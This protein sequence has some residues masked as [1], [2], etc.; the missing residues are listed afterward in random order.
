M[1]KFISC[2]IAAMFSAGVMAQPSTM[3][4]AGASTTTVMTTTIDN[5]C[6]TIAF[7]MNGMTS[8]DITLPQLNGMATIPSFTISNAAFAMGANHVVTFPEQTF[9]SSVMDNGVEKTIT[10]TS[11]SG[12]YNMADNSFDITAVLKYGAMPLPLTYHIKGYYIKSVTNSI[13]VVVG[14]SFTYK[15]ESVTYNVRKYIEDGIEKVDVEVPNYTL[16]ATVIG[17]LNVGY[18]TIKGL[19]YD[20]EK[21]GYYR[22]YKDDGLSFHFTAV[23]NGMTTMDGDYTF[24]PNKDNNILVQYTGNQI[25]GI[26]N[27]FQMG[28]MPFGI[29]STFGSIAS[30][31]EEIHSDIVNDGKAF[32]LSG[33]PAGANVK[34]IVIIGGRKYLRQ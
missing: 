32:D 1:H 18:Y 30:G 9:T 27:T 31:I 22:D 16:D 15:N 25:T 8:G 12:T 7:N 21:G 19:T 13:E 11:L 33:R 34:G 24:N 20:E 14:G 3:K 23:N 10:G 5:V 4:F 28:S 2:V 17:N 26:R 29:V 6:D